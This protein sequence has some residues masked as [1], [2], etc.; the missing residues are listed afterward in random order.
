M[1]MNYYSCDCC[2]ELRYEEYISWCA[3]CGKTLCVN[4]VDKKHDY[5]SFEPFID[6]NGYIKEEYCPFCSG[7][8]VHNNDLLEFVLKKLNLTKDEAIKLYKESV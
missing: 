7:K 5:E 4:C 1:S 6:D 3:K 2:G 8:K